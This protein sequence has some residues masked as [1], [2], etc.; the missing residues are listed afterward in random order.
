MPGPL[1]ASSPGQ[2]GTR[3]LRHCVFLVKIA[4]RLKIMVT[5][6]AGKQQ[7]YGYHGQGGNREANECAGVSGDATAVGSLR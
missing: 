5:G 3:T 6:E 4:R 1:P 2:D 7:K